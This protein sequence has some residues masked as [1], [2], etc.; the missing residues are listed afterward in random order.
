[1]AMF[2]V[3]SIH[4]QIYSQVMDIPILM[5]FQILKCMKLKCTS[6]NAL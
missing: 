6:E 4:I 2:V 1:V 3:K 5:T